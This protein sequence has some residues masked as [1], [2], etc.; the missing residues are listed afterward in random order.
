MK[1]LI[2]AYACSPQRGSEP[3]VGWDS[4]VAIAKNHDCWVVTSAKFKSEIESR[5]AEEPLTNVRFI[6]HGPNFKWIGN[7][8][9][10]RVQTWL[11]Y[12]KWQARVVSVAS[13][14]HKEVGFDVVHHVTLTAWR[15]PP[16]VCSLPVPFVWGP[17]GGTAEVPKQFFSQLSLTARCFELARKFHTALGVHASSLNKCLQKT[18]VLLAAN[19]ETKAFF[20]R[21]GLSA[22]IL[23][24]PAVYFSSTRV[25][26]L[27]RPSIDKRTGPLR[28]FAGGTLQGSKG[29]SLA[30]RAL[31]RVRDSGLD[32]DYTIAGHGPETGALRDLVRSLGLSRHVSL[33]PPF[34]GEAYVAQL[35]ACDVYLM[36]SFR[37]TTPVT[38]LEAMLA[39]CYPVVANISA[40]GEIVREMGGEAVS[41]ESVQDL[42]CNLANAVSRIC[43]KRKETNEQASLIAERVARKYQIGT[44]GDVVDEAYQLALARNPTQARKLQQ[45]HAV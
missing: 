35:H 6:Y 7:G 30:I 21:H 27:K 9:L 31:A 39:G 40:P 24:L 4:V 36:P 43:R 17:V 34:T 15:M 20:V 44:Y 11:L 8:L 18:S 45:N 33:V 41:C 2:L 37:E 12:K 22:P 16:R 28:L 19:E 14:L 38:L 26:E 13:R 25:H 42:I 23:I 5:L 3:K 1:V 32:F 29:I 10:A